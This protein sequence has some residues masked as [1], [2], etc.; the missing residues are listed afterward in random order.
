MGAQKSILCNGQPFDSI[1]TLS[2]HFGISKQK[3][4]RRLAGGWTPE[5]AVG[6]MPPRKRSGSTGRPLEFEGVQYGSLAAAEALGLD[7]KLI[8]A[9]VAK[10]Y[11]REDALRGH[12]KGRAG[13][14]K[15]IEFRREV[16]R[17]PR[18]ALLQV[19]PNLE[20]RAKTRKPRLDHG[21]SASN[22][23]CAAP[24]QRL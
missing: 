2:E 18:A 13:R 19:W 11:A 21:A 17:R 14:G 16:Y 24:I 20:Q 6:I 9:R 1:T 12:L 4:T 10:G 5:Q 7:P 8:A 15:A 23:A 22:R 3:V